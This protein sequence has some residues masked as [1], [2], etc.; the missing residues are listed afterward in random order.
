M[1]GPGLCGVAGPGAWGLGAGAGGTSAEPAP[2]F[3]SVEGAPSRA[4]PQRGRMPTAA[5]YRDGLAG[6]AGHHGNKALLTSPSVL[7]PTHPRPST[8]PPLFLF[9]VFHIA[10]P[11]SSSV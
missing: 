5:C 9:F 7:T 2:S 1:V 3:Q 8:F 10:S 11:I 4:G 6:A